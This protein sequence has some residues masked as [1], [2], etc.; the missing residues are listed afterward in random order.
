[1]NVLIVDDSK[2]AR[3][4]L[5]KILA[6]NYPTWVRKEAGNADEALQLASEFA[7]DIVLMDYNMPGRDGLALA[8]DFRA[9]DPSMR[10]ALISANQQHEIVEGA[11]ALGASFLTKPVNCPDLVAFLGKPDTPI[12]Q[13]DQ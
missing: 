13:D 8:A 2:L 9:Q 10:L 6:K 12:G 1:M 11:K 4:A 3:M 7:A 5:V